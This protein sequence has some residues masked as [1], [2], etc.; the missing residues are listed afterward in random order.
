ME[1]NIIEAF[2][3]RLAWRK[4]KALLRFRGNGYWE[5]ISWNLAAEKVRQIAAGLLHLGLKK[6]DRAC[7]L[8]RNRHEWFL[9]DFGILAAG[10]VTVPIYPTLLA[11]DVA[12]IVK[13]S[14]AKFIFVENEEQKQKILAA[15][16][17]L[18]K[19]QK[20]IIFEQHKL[21]EFVWQLEDLKDNGRRFLKQ[22]ADEAVEAIA[23]KISPADLAT[24]VYTSGTTGPP[25][26]S[27][28]THENIFFVCQALEKVWP[29]QEGDVHLSY[30]P[31]AHVYERL[32]GHFFVMYAGGVIA[33]ARSIDTILEDAQVVKPTVFLGVPRV[34]EK[35]A[36]RIQEKVK[37]G[38]ALTRSLFEWATRVGDQAARFRQKKQ[39]L[40]LPLRVQ[41]EL[42][43]ALVYRKLRE[44]LGGKVK[45]LV[46]AAAP[47]SPEIQRFL[48]SLGFFL[49]EGYGLTESTAPAT[50]NLPEAYKI[51]TVGKPLPGV[52][53]KIARDGE[54]LIKGKS[55]FKGYFK[56][57]EASEEVLRRGW[58]HT[59]DVGEIDEDGFLKITDRK[60]DIII[61]AGG[62]NIAPQN[63]ENRLKMHPLI[64]QAVI[65]GDQRPYLT[66]LI[67]LD[68][69]ELHKLAAKKGWK[70]KNYA[71]LAKHRE[72]REELEKVVEE[73]N[74]HLARYETIKKFA[75]LERDFSIESGELTPTLKVKRRVINEKFREIIDQMYAS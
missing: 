34:Y 11:E 30:L 17:K 58:L 60:K 45:F 31:L 27:E 52:K 13:H 38:S 8:S 7:I 37:Q 12:Y 21:E 63:I 41:V 42:A 68:E 59:G 10:G 9:A 24:L 64:S 51:G 39:G 16:K 26:G 25:K 47:L 20:T 70:E 57:K 66:A 62:K 54:I 74:R 75:I 33:Y 23:R 29:F 56:N 44:L 15:R 6:G 2:W 49:L 18:P 53:V 69:Q 48:Q 32:G 3:N 43:E 22:Y 35:M 65:I 61:T 55:I 4:R 50:L 73:H 14:E 46:S 28:I 72:V 40:P 71:S 1:K 5:D 67:T 19:L 36:Q